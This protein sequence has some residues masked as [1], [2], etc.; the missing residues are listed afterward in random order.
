[1]NTVGCTLHAVLCRT[2][3]ANELRGATEVPLLALWGWEVLPAVLADCTEGAV[4]RLMCTK[5]AP[6]GAPVCLQTT[7]PEGMRVVRVGGGTAELAVPGQYSAELTLVPAPRDDVTLAKYRTPP[8]EE[9]AGGGRALPAFVAGWLNDGGVLKLCALLGMQCVE[10]GLMPGVLG[11][12]R[13]QELKHAA[14]SVLRCCR[15]SCG[16]GGHAAACWRQRGSS[17]W[18]RG[19]CSSA[20]A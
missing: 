11:A 9:P 7:L 1:M 13:P 3:T 12:L 5:P 4:W 2:S 20:A 17:S 6:P 14:A 8:T 19:R 18:R 15:A 10:G 16:H